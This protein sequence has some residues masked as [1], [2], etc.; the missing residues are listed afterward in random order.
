MIEN[1][2]Y[3]KSRIIA[4]N[5]AGGSLVL[6]L[7]L[8]S[9]NSEN[10][11]DCFQNAGDLVRVQVDVPDFSDITVFER[12]NLVLI[13]GEEQSVEIESGE[14]LLNE[15]SATVE[16]GRLIL[17]NDNGCNLFREY[18]LSTVYV[19]AP[20]INEV[21]SST[22]LLISS[23]GVLNYPDIRLV[24]ESFSENTSETTSGSFDLQLA[25]QNVQLLANGIAYFR[26]RGTAENL[27]VFIAAGDSRI[28]AEGLSATSVTVN[29]R[30][31]ND[32]LVNP[33]QRISGTIRGYGDVISVNRPEE[34][35][36]EE[37]FEGRL[38]FQD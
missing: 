1:K 18:G 37:T 4:L 34:V 23:E 32:I 12:L 25:S 31:T 24:S 36:V 28:E 10:A 20:D 29:H 2:R 13:Q 6:L 7:L 11:P 26:I 3:S 5:I 16:D 17:R 33:Q 21:R 15:I 9:C 22:G 14:L 35:M 19:K 8:L 30:G 27:N 38:I